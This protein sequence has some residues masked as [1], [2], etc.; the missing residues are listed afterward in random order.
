VLSSKSFIAL[1]LS[2]VSLG[3]TQNSSYTVQ[4]GDTLTHIAE[5]F[6]LS[7]ADLAAVNKL[8]NPNLLEVG[9]ELL[10]PSLHAWDEPLPPP[11]T[12]VS[13]S[14]QTATQGEAQ[15]LGVELEGLE[16]E[17]EA[18][19]S[20]TPI[21]LAKTDEGYEGILATPV[22]RPAGTSSLLLKAAHRG[23]T[24]TVLLPVTVVQGDYDREQITLSAETSQL[25]APDIVSRE[26]ALMET[27]CAQ[28]EP[29]QRWHAPFTLPVANPEFTSVFGT[30]RSYNGGPYSGFHRGLDFRG[31]T[32]TPVYAA[33]P[34]VVSLSERLE[35]YGN[36][37]ILDH[38]LGVCSAY[39]HL[40]ERQAEV[41][42]A[43]ETGDPVGLIGE[44]GLV[45]GAHLHWEVRVNGV[46]VAP[47][48]WT[49]E[50]W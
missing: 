30:L 15:R 14:P 29:V 18:S 2:F 5:T 10:V 31:A 49:Q 11:F 33:A 44:T 12:S 20:G 4:P 40:S 38:G 1:L 7:A 34:G 28:F 8:E 23:A 37:V 46:P 43:L 17:L 25:L 27:T 42:Q 6:G 21:L 48:Q 13:L 32:G 22:L 39:M 3:W 16:I 45:T 36:T 26:H 50:T 9:Q 41:G 24:T 47:L 35:L 19:Y